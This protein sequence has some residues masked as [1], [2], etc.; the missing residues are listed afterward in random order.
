MLLD[1]PQT[2]SRTIF[3]EYSESDTKN[4]CLMVEEADWIARRIKMSIFTGAA[5]AIATPFNDDYSVN[6]EKLDNLIEFQIK[7]GT[8]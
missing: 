2:V 1:E 8:R 6:Y 3:S 4:S 7:N 5:V